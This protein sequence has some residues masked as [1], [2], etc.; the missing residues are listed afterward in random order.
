MPKIFEKSY[1]L[2]TALASVTDDGSFYWRSPTATLQVTIEYRELKRIAATVTHYSPDTGAT[3]KWRNKSTSTEVD[4]VETT[5]S[6]RNTA[7]SAS[8]TITTG[9]QVSGHW[10]ADAEL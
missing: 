10:A 5:S 6:E 7:I 9:Q 1:D 8:T 3:S 2:D 4:T